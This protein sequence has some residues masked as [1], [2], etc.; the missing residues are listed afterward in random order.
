MGLRRDLLALSP[1]D[2]LR[3]DFLALRPGLPALRLDPLSRL[4]SLR[5][6][7][8]A[9]RLDLPA[10][11]LKKKRKLPP[12]RNIL[13]DDASEALIILEELRTVT[14]EPSFIIG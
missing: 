12:N 13:A 2:P 1:A 4:D 3:L 14:Q 8:P 7:L 5:L 6:D 11:G 10:L 9:L